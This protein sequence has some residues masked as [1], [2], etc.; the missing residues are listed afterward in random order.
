[1]VATIALLLAPLAVA[2]AIYLALAS[3][4][5]GG[6]SPS[7]PIAVHTPPVPD[8]AEERPKPKLPGVDL[9]G[10]DAFHVL[11]HKPPR[12]GLV[13]DLGSG[14]VLWRR[15]TRCGCCRSRA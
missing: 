8:K 3:D 1:M 5:G 9:T 11:L 13:F 6:Q 14:D 2:A 12:A 7:L 4:A 10:V 15:A